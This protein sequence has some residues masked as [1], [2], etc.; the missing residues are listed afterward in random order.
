MMLLINGLM[1]C[2]ACLICLADLYNIHANTN[3]DIVCKKNRK[4]MHGLH[5]EV[6]FSLYY[7][8]YGFA[9]M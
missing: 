7:I 5:T 3:Y 9:P 1:P 6:N 2:A 4:Y 8:L